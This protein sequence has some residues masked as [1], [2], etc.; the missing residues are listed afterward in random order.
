[1]WSG[2]VGRESDSA[3]GLVRFMRAG[4][5]ERGN[6]S[7]MMEVVEVEVEGDVTAASSGGEEEV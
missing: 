6:G 2:R 4:G 7:F 5:G 1:M 3:S